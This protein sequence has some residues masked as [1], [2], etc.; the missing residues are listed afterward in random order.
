MPSTKIIRLGQLQIKFHWVVAL[1]VVLLISGLVRLGI[2]QLHRAAEKNAGKNQTAAL[3]AQT[4]R[5]IE[6]LFDGT[7][8]SQQQ[9]LSTVN[10]SLLGTYLD[11]KAI[12]V[13]NQTYEEQIGYEVLVPFRLQSN[14]KLILVS[15]GWVTARGFDRPL[16]YVPPV[17]GTVEVTG[18][19]QTKPITTEQKNKIDKNHSPMR[20]AHV[21]MQEISTLLGESVFPYVVRLNEGEPGILIRHW[22]TVSVNVDQNYSYALQWFAMAIAVFIVSVYL[23]SNLPALLRQGKDKDQPER[24]N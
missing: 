18:L 19:L 2:W 20:I 14:N 1:F 21:D 6:G 16:D 22:K 23:S 4:P 9:D 3:Q 11:N 7:I 15:R 13:A 17:K 10:L 8:N 24:I 5:P 12:W